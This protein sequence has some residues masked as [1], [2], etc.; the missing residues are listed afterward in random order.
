MSQTE[1]SPDALQ[2]QIDELARRLE[3]ADAERHSL[4]V[5][6]DTAEAQADHDREMIVDLQAQGVVTEQHSRDLELA[7]R[8]SRTIGKAVGILMESRK[9]SE[10]DAFAVLKQAS[11][12]GN[13]K[14][15]EIAAEIVALSGPTT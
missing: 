4:N 2:S 5:R 3:K 8:S 15:R 7:L 10:D 11:Q 12:D 6:A 13:R 9:L 14:L 1:S